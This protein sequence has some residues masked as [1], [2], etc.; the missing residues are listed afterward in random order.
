M[1]GFVDYLPMAG[2]I[3]PR[4]AEAIRTE[5]EMKYKAREEAIH[6]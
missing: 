1:M 2:A 5:D 3:N 4:V 6:S